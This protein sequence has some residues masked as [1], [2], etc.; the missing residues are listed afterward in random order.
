MGATVV[1]SV[2]AAVHRVSSSLGDASAV[3]VC[4]AQTVNAT[5]S[6]CTGNA[7]RQMDPAPANQATGANSAGSRV[8]LG[9]TGRTAETSKK[10]SFFGVA[11]FPAFST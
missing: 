9:S 3:T 6:A 4:G 1:P 11:I 10:N 8:L 2:P 5:V 7:T